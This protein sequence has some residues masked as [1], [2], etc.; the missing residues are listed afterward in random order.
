MRKVIFATLIILCVLL[1]AMPAIADS[2]IG[3]Y[4]AIRMDDN[5]TFIIDTKEGHLWTWALKHRTAALFYC[6]RVKQGTRM[7]EIIDKH[8]ITN[9]AESK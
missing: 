1:V 2:E 3:R 7:M 4:Q 9:S 8:I 5:V 6:G